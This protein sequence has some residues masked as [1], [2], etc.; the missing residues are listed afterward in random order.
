MFAYLKIDPR[1]LKLQFFIYPISRNGGK[2]SNSKMSNSDGI[3]QTKPPF[4]RAQ[5]GEMKK[6]K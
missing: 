3:V 5:R 6:E 2:Q 4:S 1:D